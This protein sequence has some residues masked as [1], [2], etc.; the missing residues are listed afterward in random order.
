VAIALVTF[1]VLTKWKAPEPIIIGVSGLIGI[2][3]QLRS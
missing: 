1:L 3:L 2:V